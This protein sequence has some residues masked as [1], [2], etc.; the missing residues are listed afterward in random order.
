MPGDQLLMS[1]FLSRLSFLIV[2]E[3]QIVVAFER[4]SLI[5]PTLSLDFETDS[6][7]SV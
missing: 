5:S 1:L 3:G 7:P 2:V 4:K 6:T